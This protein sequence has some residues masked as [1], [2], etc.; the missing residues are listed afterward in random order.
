[1]GLRAFFKS[2]PEPLPAKTIAIGVRYYEEWLAE[3]TAEGG[4]DAAVMAGRWHESGA[5]SR[6]AYNQ[7][8]RW[9][10]VRLQ[11]ALEAT[12]KDLKANQASSEEWEQ[13]RQHAAGL[14]GEF[15]TFAAWGK[16]VEEGKV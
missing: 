15:E 3:A 5:V 16:R 7:S 9:H 6:N 12:M 10:R 13:A 11:K 8:I 14:A 1:M 2:E 4:T